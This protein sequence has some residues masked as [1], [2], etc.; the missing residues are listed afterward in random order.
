M[1]KLNKNI[2]KNREIF[3]YF[4][5][6]G[7]LMKVSIGCMNGIHYALNSYYKYIPIKQEK[8]KHHQMHD[9]PHECSILLFSFFFFFFQQNNIKF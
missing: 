2:Q 7:A 4:L 9:F 8:Y 6:N 3:H 1:I 5:K